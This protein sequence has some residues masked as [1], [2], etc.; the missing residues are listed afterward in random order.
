MH[1]RPYLHRQ[2]T[3]AG[4]T[5]VYRF[6]IALSILSLETAANWYKTWYR[7]LPKSIFPANMEVHHHLHV[8]KKTFKEYFLEFTMIFLA[9]AMGFFCGKFQGKI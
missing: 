4:A 1:F 8:D 9:V 6:Q 3:P 7:L 5:H 2:L